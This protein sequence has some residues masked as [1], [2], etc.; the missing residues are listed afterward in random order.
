MTE[1]QPRAIAGFWACLLA[2][3]VDGTLLALVGLAIGYPFRQEL[4]SMGAWGRLLGFCVALVYFGC[5]NSQLAGG[6]SPGKRL[7][8][9]K[10]VDAAAAPLS[11][12]RSFVRFLPLGAAWF[13][14]GLALPPST[15]DS[16]LISE[17]LTVAIFGVGLSTV[18]LYLFNRVTRQSVHDLLVG[19]YVVKASA[20]DHVLHDKVW[21]VHYVVCGVLLVASALAPLVAMHFLGTEPFAS[22]QG[23]YRTVID[24]PRVTNAHV[25]RGNLLTSKARSSYL[26]IVVYTTDPSIDDAARARQIATSAYAAAAGESRDVDR[27]NLTMVYGF[28]IGISSFW[29]SQGFSYAPNELTGTSQKAS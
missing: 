17:L 10:V 16:V 6:Q 21:R 14:N 4:V 26:S 9:I 22:M 1:E 18:Y 8:K 20:A 28:D 12:Q 25:T 5:F 7:L 13:L 24:Q 15:L 2:F 19:S 27:V 23:V 3:M 29:R 11:V